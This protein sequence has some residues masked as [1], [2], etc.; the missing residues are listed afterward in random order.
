MTNKYWFKPKSY[1]YGATPT[2]WEGWAFT[3]AFIAVVLWRALK[4]EEQAP[5]QFALELGLLIL[6][7]IVV[8][9]QKTDGEWKWR[10]EK[11]NRNS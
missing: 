9:K 10:W 4:L 3:A 7:L 5:S 1:G 6:I 11:G 2:T 8:T